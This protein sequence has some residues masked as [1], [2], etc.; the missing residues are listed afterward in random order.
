MST[1][2]FALYSAAHFAT[3]VF[4]IRILRRY[5]APGAIII[6]ALSIGLIYDNGLIALG[7]TIGIGD[8]L[9][10]LSIPRFV[11]HALITPLMIIAVVQVAIASGISW[12]A[13]RS[14]WIIIWLLTAAMIGY[15][16]YELTI[17]ELQPACFNG[18]TRYTSSAS[19]IQYCFEGQQT[20]PGLG[21]PI[22]SIV[23]VL[24]I[25]GFGVVMWRRHGWPWYSLGGLQMLLAAGVPFSQFG[26]LPGNGGEV[27][28]QFAFVS[29]AYRFSRGWQPKN[30][31]DSSVTQPG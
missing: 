6:A 5:S 9:E 20:L 1:V 22:P 15:G 19:A 31:P 12:L 2:L 24:L 23:A 28:L 7:S 16:I 8:T 17:L 13:T 26:L 21:P 4:A 29:T 25:I 18:I 11:M 10:M 27:I 14:S 30:A 3:A